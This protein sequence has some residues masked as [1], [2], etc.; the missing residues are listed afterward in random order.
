[1]SLRTRPV[2]RGPRPVAPTTG[3]PAARTRSSTSWVY[4]ETVS[5]L[6]TSVPSRSVAISLG[7]P[8]RV[9]VPPSPA[10]VA[11]AVVVV[12]ASAHDRRAAT[13]PRGSGRN[14]GFP[15]NRAPTRGDRPVTFR[16]FAEAGGL[17]G[18]GRRLRAGERHGGLN[19]QV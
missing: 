10:A 19:R 9:I 6:R 7:R 2:R 14:H 17:Q 18:S 11:P 1:M 15:A 8:G 3:I 12:G 5:S 13:V 4:A 16:S